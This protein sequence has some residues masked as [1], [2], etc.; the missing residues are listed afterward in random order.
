MWGLWVSVLVLP[1]RHQWQPTPEQHL[2]TYGKEAW[3]RTHGKGRDIWKLTPSPSWLSES[4]P[5]A[6]LTLFLTH[7]AELFW[8]LIYPHY[9]FLFSISVSVW[10]TQMVAGKW[11]Y[12]LESCQAQQK[13]FMR[14]RLL[15]IS[16]VVSREHTVLCRCCHIHFAWGKLQGCIIVTFFKAL[17]LSRRERWR[18]KVVHQLGTDILNYN[19]EKNVKF[20]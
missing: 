9:W 10:E 2:Q 20:Q 4:F 8:H 5:L 18:E 6:S 7:A 17:L 11:F 19:T 14:A 16:D 12:G 13:S 3:F 15:L 1:F